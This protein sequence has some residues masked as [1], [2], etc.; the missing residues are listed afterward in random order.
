MSSQS[1]GSPFQIASG[2]SPR[3]DSA[4]PDHTVLFVCHGHPALRPGGAEQ[5]A[6]E[7]YLALKGTPGFRTYFVARLGPNDSLPGPAV[8]PGGPVFARPDDPNTFFL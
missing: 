2:V 8:V 6:H 1:A 4:M 5:Y 3:L 7:L